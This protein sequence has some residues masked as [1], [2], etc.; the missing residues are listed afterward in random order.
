[1]DAEEGIRRSLE[2]ARNR[3]R[4]TRVAM[5]AGSTMGH[6]E[7]DQAD[8]EA[9]DDAERQMA[10][11]ETRLNRTIRDKADQSAGK[12]R[13]TI[14]VVALIGSLVVAGAVALGVLQYRGVVSPLQRLTKG[15]RRLAAGQFDQRL[16]ER[17]T[18]EFET[19]ADEFN[20]MAGELD[21]FYHRL[22]EKVAQKGRELTRTERLASVGYLAA[23]VAHE[24]NNPIG[25][26]AGYAEYSLSQLKQ[27]PASAGNED[28]AKSL[29]VILDEAF[30][31][32]EIVGQLL[33]LARPGE[34]R[35]TPV[36]LSK[37]ARDV[38]AMVGG[39]RDFK[40]R[41][42]TVNATGRA[43][44][45]TVNAAEAEMKQVVLNLTVNAM[46]AV[47]PGGE[48]KIDVGRRDGTVELRV[49]DN[50]RGMTPE[51]LDRVFEPF[52]TE[53]RGARQPGSGLGLSIS[54]AIIES[55]G[56]HITASSAGPGTGSEFLVRLPAADANQGSRS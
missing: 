12:R 35:R 47:P 56:G 53:K 46:D 34:A 16:A 49:R 26:I 20:R 36:D 4:L 55:H 28:L 50:G 32:K 33:S 6:A 13:R 29:Q 21:G 23:G 9:I 17:G 2:G 24:I 15:V 14:L 11:F 30:R 31:C 54:N 5:P 39:L 48:V 37:V 41:R 18:R 3:L 10:K 19:L 1:V 7:D 27:Q 45:L 8:V 52:Y 51:T 38:M 22:E 42:V 44:E 40:D 25:I 43:E